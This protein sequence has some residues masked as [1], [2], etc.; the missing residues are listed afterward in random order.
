MK[1]NLLFVG[2]QEEHAETYSKA[3]PVTL[4]DCNHTF[5]TESYKV[6][7]S[8]LVFSY[9]GRYRILTVMLSLSCTKRMMTFL[10]SIIFDEHRRL[11]HFDA[12]HLPANVDQ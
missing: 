10:N 3:L 8:V 4:N 6:Q 9:K 11:S 2:G 1:R 7:A 5:S 12:R